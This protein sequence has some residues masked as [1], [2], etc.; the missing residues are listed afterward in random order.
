MKNKQ[1][2][3]NCSFCNKTKSEA[4]VLISG[5]EGYICETCVEQAYNI[6]TEEMGIELDVA[7]PELKKDNKK[8]SNAKPNSLTPKQIKEHLDTY[9][10]GQDDTKK[11]LAVA[12]Y[13]HYKRVM[14]EKSEDEIEI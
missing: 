6:L 5:I 4:L 1:K 14:Q 9:V 11:I 2:E 8:Q 12:V 13:N 10:V 7:A 3:A